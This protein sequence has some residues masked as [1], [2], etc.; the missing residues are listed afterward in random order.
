MRVSKKDLMDRLAVGYELG[1]YETCPWSCYD[2]ESGRTCSAEV[3]MDPEGM[4]LEAEI[5]LM[6][7]TP[8]E[9]KPPM[10]QI[11]WIKSKPLQSSGEWEIADFKLRGAAPE[12]EIYNWQEKSCNFFSAFVQELQTDVIPDIDELIDR[13]FHSR[14][15]AGDQ[16]EGGGGKS[17]VIKA[18]QLLDM[19]KGGGF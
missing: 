16:S 8:P 3:R 1:S 9:G 19:K 13:E 7:D 15:R 12:E 10:E 2:G 11:F 18:N 5:Q 6:H 4:E 14:E 17:P